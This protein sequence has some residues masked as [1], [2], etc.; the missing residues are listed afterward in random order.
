MHRQT[1]R[2]TDPIESRSLES[3]KM[4]VFDNVDDLLS[5][6]NDVSNMSDSELAA[7]ESTNNYT[8]LG[9][10]A[11][12]VYNNIDFEEFKTQEELI[13]FI[14]ANSKYVSIVDDD[15]ELMTEPI[16]VGNTYRYIANEDGM[17]AIK[18]TV[19]RIFRDGFVSTAKSNISALYDFDSKNHY[20]VNRDQELTFSPFKYE[21]QTR[22]IEINGPGVVARQDQTVDRDRIVMKIECVGVNFQGVSTHQATVCGSPQKKALGMWHATSRT[23]SF[24]YY[25]EWVRDGQLGYLKESGSRS[26]NRVEYIIYGGV[27]DRRVIFR[28][29]HCWATTPS[30]DF[31]KA[32]ISH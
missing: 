28:T 13:L 14:D 32:I 1:D 23:I 12:Q 15:G 27:N 24:D 10:K 5:T 17:F 30:V 16:L 9:R 8:S 7:F 18:D 11:D 29:F 26:G 31:K 2:Q 6:T 25:A 20:S 19:Y 4:L 22:S 3:L 21:S